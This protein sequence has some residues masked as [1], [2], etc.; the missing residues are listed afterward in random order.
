VKVNVRSRLLSI[1]SIL[2]FKREGQGK[3]QTLE[4]Q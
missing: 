2:N 4:Y 1:S 3:K